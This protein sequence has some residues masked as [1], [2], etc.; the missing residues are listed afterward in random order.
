MAKRTIASLAINLV[1]NTAQLVTGFQKGERAVNK[2]A[3]N[4]KTVGVALAGY[5][6][7]NAITS[8]I[9][10]SM[11]A[12]DELGKASDQLGIATEKL[13]AYQLAADLA[14]V[15]AEQLAVGFKTQQRVLSE[16][17]QGTKTA[18][19]TFTDL[20]LNLERL[21]AMDA[22]MQFETILKALGNLTN[23]TDRTRIALELF[24][25]SGQGFLSLK[26]GDIEKAAQQIDA[27]GGAISRIDAAK[28]EEAND[29]ITRLKAALSSLGQQAAVDLAPAVESLAKAATNA[30]PVLR[31]PTFEEGAQ[32]LSRF[33]LFPQRPVVN[34]AIKRQVEEAFAKARADAEFTI[35]SAEQRA[36][37]VASAEA[38][39]WDAVMDRAGARIEETARQAEAV[40]EL[41][42]KFWDEYS[43]NLQQAEQAAESIRQGLRTPIEQISDEF[44]Q[45]AQAFNMGFLDQETMDRAESQLAEQIMEIQKAKQSLSFGPAGG[46]GAVQKGTT[47]AFSAIQ[48]AGREYRA[49]AARQ[50]EQKRL[51][52]EANTI[53]NDIKKNTAERIEITEAGI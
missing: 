44:Y 10:S 34:N 37:L 19:D 26:P 52:A 53:L 47:E 8:W 21:A 29:S 43:Q 31:P 17:I 28:V 35:K 33:G 13:Q 30:V 49:M 15:S 5:F 7:V 22:A 39:S 16:A 51:Q 24:G 3:A 14:G 45:A 27:V 4:M 32:R 48:A 2:F 11:Q 38:E 46:V 40:F 9:S 36:Q 1:A 12:I 6:S 25:R 18:R 42:S 50:E 41:G 23:Q 20:G